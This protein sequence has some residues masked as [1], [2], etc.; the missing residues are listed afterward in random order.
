MGCLNA[1]IT[2]KQTSVAVNIAHIDTSILVSVNQTCDIYV[3][4]PI[5]TTDG[6]LYAADAILYTKN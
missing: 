3:G 4:I 6:R 1:V 5:Y 2:L